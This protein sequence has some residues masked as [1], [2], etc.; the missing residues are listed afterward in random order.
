MLFVVLF[1]LL[2]SGAHQ[3][4]FS[5]NLKKVC[6]AKPRLFE[7]PRFCKDGL[8][9][10]HKKQDTS[11]DIPKTP[12]KIIEIT[13]EIAESEQARNQ[14]LMYRHTLESRAGM[15]FMFP[16]EALR[17]FYMK[18]TIIPLDIIFVN[19][20]KEIVSMQK[21]ATPYSLKI[22]PSEKPA[23]YAVEV[24]AGFCEEHGIAVGDT[25]SFKRV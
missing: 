6:L 21:N 5:R 17:L 4:V 16:D 14:G 22:L 13:I 11:Q 15:L 8:L 10:F 19:R 25:I 12:T 23:H 9:S 20:K 3:E 18:N 24:N 7:Q 2:V 1:L